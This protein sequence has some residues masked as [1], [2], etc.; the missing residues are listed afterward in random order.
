M[1]RNKIIPVLI[2]LLMVVLLVVSLDSGSSLPEACQTV[3]QHM[4]TRAV[5]DRGPRMFLTYDFNYD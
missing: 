5:R 4:V 3:S 1:H 2:R